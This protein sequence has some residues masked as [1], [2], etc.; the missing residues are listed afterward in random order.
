MNANVPM[1]ELVCNACGLVFAVP[2]TFR[3]GLFASKRM[4]YCPSG[5]SLAFPSPPPPASRKRKRAE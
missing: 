2:E 3:A 1:T 4:F 5:H